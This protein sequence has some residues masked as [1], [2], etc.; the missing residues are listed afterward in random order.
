MKPR[1]RFIDIRGLKLA[2]HD[3]G[4]ED[5]PV[6]FCTHGILDHG[7]S[8]AFVAEALEGQLRLVAPDMR[9]HGESG[10]VGAGGYYHF[11]DYYFDVHQLATS[12]ELGDGP[13]LLAGH[14][15]GGSVTTGLAALLGGRAHG[16]LLLEG[17]GPP[18]N[19]E[20]APKRLRRWTEALARP[21]LPGPAEAR[22][23]GRPVLSSLE[24]A[25]ER[26]MRW[27]P[28]LPRERALRY[29]ET[30]TEAH[31]EGFVWRYDPLHR[32]PAA[33][34][35]NKAEAEAVWAAIE[36]P[37]ISL[38]GEH[39]YAPP[40]LEARHDCLR[41][42]VAGVIPG[43]GHNIHHER[44]DLVA[45]ALLALRNQPLVLPDGIRPL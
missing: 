14:S 42:V 12:G 7:Q 27:N 21:T 9:G 26:L 36:A 1:T 5:A 16:V 10:W 35:F 24:S 28:R 20:E 3:Y 13:L 33:K 4:P 40:D 11:Y 23:A 25:A 43:V 19:A 17:M 32:T 45:A 29:A 2:F 39:G 44:P 41:S 18:F 30:F 15:M 38:L 31:G 37:V 34:P 22:Q 8:W 6:V